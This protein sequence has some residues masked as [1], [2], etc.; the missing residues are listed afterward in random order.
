MIAVHRVQLH[1][2]PA[3]I[4][5]DLDRKTPFST[6]VFVYKHARPLDEYIE[7]AGVAK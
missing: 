2:F 1:N 4:S 6:T 3:K 7:L 5:A